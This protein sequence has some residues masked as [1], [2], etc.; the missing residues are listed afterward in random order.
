MSCYFIV[1]VYIDEYR[2]I[3]HEREDNESRVHETIQSVYP[4][5]TDVKTICDCV[6]SAVKAELA[7]K[8]PSG[9]TGCLSTAVVEAIAADVYFDRKKE[10]V[11][12]RAGADV[13]LQNHADNSSYAVAFQEDGKKYWMI[14]TGYDALPSCIS[15]VSLTVERPTHKCCCGERLIEE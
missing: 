6:R 10:F 8:F 12:D 2:Q 7:E 1:D 3:M 13:Y 11:N 15:G 14:H 4:Y 5:E 9:H